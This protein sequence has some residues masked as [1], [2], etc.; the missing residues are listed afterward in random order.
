[1]GL[2]L[3][4]IEIKSVRSGITKE[5]KIKLKVKKVNKALPE[6]S[7]IKH[8]MKN[9]FPKSEQLPLWLL[10]LLARRKC[11]DFL[12]YYDNGAF[13][14]IS[15]TVHSESM[16]FVLYLAISEELRSKG[17]GSLILAHIKDSFKGKPIS[18]NIEPLDHK[19]ENYIQRMKRFAFYQKNGFSDTYYMLEVHNERY[20][21]LSTSTEFKIEE[22]TA[23]LRKL[24]FG[25]PVSTIKQI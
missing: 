8:L 4:F 18:L 7:K 11:I 22:Y 20:Q 3:Y 12:A 13:C 6:Y 19:A 24:S 25:I 15:Y 9:S 1:M 21:I 2:T 17:Y 5:V 16:V 10:R 23:V 14:G